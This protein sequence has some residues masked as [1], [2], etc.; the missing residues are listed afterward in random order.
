MNLNAGYLVVD[1][2]ELIDNNELNP[3]E[4]SYFKIFLQNMGE[5]ALED[6]VLNLLPSG[7]LID[8]LDESTY[9]GSINP[10]QIVGSSDNSPLFIAIN[11]NTINSILYLCM[12]SYK[13]CIMAKFILYI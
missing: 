13:F 9:F 12:K 8:I 10:N 7:L 4:E 1:S 11:E 2:I 6:V 5:H 3:S